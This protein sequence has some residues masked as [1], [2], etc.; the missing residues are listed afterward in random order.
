MNRQKPR[1]VIEVAAYFDGTATV[2]EAFSK[3]YAL[4]LGARRDAPKSSNRTFEHG[5]IAG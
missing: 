3:V 5:E 2:I 4:I 1:P